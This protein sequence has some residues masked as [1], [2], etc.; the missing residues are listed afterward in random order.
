[1]RTIINRVSTATA[2]RYNRFLQGIMNQDEQETSISIQRTGL[3]DVPEDNSTERR[4]AAHILLGINNQRRNKDVRLLDDNRDGYLG[5]DENEKSHRIANEP[6]VVKEVNNNDEI[7]TSTKIDHLK[8]GTTTE[9]E[10]DDKEETTTPKNLHS[11]EKGSTTEHEHA[12]NDETSKPTKTP[13]KP[14]NTEKGSP[15]DHEHENDD[16]LHSSEKGSTTEHEHVNNDETSKPT[17]I[18]NLKKGTTTK[19]ND[20]MERKASSDGSL[21]TQYPFKDDTVPWIVSNSSKIDAVVQDVADANDSEQSSY[22]HDDDESN[23][24]SGF[25]SDDDESNITSMHDDY[26]SNGEAKVP[27]SV[28]VA[29]PKKEDG[30]SIKFSDNNNHI[31]HQIAKLRKR[32]DNK[33]QKTVVKGRKRTKQIKRLPGTNCSFLPASVAREVIN[34]P[35]ELNFKSKKETNVLDAAVSL[36]AMV[37]VKINAGDVKD[38]FDHRTKHLWEMRPSTIRRAYNRILERHNYVLS[39]EK[40][41]AKEGGKTQWRRGSI[42]QY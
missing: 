35:I 8:K 15:T 1:M 13:T 23:G 2:Y 26:A 7:T 28:S 32:K 18:K 40:K 30:I 4:T 14:R 34:V 10:P 37:G 25:A 17:K 42:K 6:A 12:N 33:K 41:S 11:S 19:H 5:D 29:S 9:L 22:G 20:T 16:K 38:E 36:L 31:N 27:T 39:A 3:E 21:D 24:E